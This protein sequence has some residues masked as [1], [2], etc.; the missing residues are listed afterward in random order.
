MYTERIYIDPLPVVRDLQQFQSSI[1]HEYF[2]RCRA[3]IHGILYQF[4]QRMDRSNNDLS[5]GN[6]V[7][8]ILIKCLD[9]TI[10]LFSGDGLDPLP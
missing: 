1:F 9:K 5:G 6:F 7:H 4:F 2:Q 10:S 8:D 3:G